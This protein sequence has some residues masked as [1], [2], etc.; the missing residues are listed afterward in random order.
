[1]AKEY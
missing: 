1:V